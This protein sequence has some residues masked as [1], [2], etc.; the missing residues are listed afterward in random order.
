MASSSKLRTIRDQV[1]VLMGS[2]RIAE[3][4]LA[5][6][7]RSGLSIWILADLRASLAE[8]RSQLGD[9]RKAMAAEL[10]RIS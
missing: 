7:E 5:R 9:A 2:V 6:A 8:Y 10:E 1:S 4:E 3:N